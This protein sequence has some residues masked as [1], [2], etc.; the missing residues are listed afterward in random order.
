VHCWQS[1]AK[2]QA[3]DLELPRDYQRV[4]R[5][6]NS[7]GVIPERLERRCDI[8]SLSDFRCDH[9]I[10]ERLRCGLSVAHFQ[11]RGAIRGICQDGQSAKTGYKLAQDFDPL[12][13]K[14]S[15]LVRQ[16]G[17]IPARSGE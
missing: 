5:D 11:Y 1:R 9:L 7:V 16:A 17:E 4:D 3:I 8:L 13:S 14:I 15:G 10:S 12:S 2:R 6:V